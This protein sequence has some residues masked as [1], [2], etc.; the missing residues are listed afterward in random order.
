[1]STDNTQRQHCD[2]N[3]PRFCQEISVVYT[4]S[5]SVLLLVCGMDISKYFLSVKC[6][7]EAI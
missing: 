7:E 4:V 2:N 1:M 3:T 5:V 6:V